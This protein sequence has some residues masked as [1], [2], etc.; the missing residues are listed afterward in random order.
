MR[1]IF[2]DGTAK[3]GFSISSPTAGGFRP[4][5]LGQVT[6]EAMSPARMP[7]TMGPNDM[8]TLEP[9][10]D[11]KKPDIKPQPLPAIRV[12]KLDNPRARFEWAVG[13]LCSVMR[14]FA[15]QDIPDDAKSHIFWSYVK[16]SGSSEESVLTAYKTL[17]PELP[18]PPKPTTPDKEL[19]AES[20][21]KVGFHGKTTLS[22][23]EAQQLKEALDEVLKPL[24]PEETAKAINSQECLRDLAA[25]NYPK[26]EALRD[27]LADFV[28]AGDKNATFEISK[29]DVVVAG[30]AID[31]AVAIGRGAAIKTA[32]TAGGVLG[33][34]ALLLFLL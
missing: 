2:A 26:V 33:A 1:N 28:A 23:D 29:G 16:N 24:T 4:V 12:R 31:C 13:R 14:H 20:P 32:L 18:V 25:G 8:P 15:D 11:Q 9:G 6:S 10:G 27:D 21:D 22:F 30:K 7:H 34:G 17:C 3:N 19:V 5:K